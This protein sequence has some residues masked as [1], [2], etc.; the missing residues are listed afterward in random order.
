MRNLSQ[1]IL[2]LGVFS[3]ILLF[4]ARMAH[5]T[6]GVLLHGVGAVDSA[7]GG[8]S[9][10]ISQDSLGALTNNPATLSDLKATRFDFGFGLILPRVSM[11]SSVGPFSGKTNAEKDSFP[12]PAFGLAH[13]PKES[14][15]TFGFGVLGVSGF[16]LDY[17]QDSSNPLLAPSPAGLGHIFSNYQLLKIVPSVAYKPGSAVSVGFALNL[18]L[19]SMALQPT[20]FAA[21]D[22]DTATSCFYPSASNAANAYGIGFQLGIQYRLSDQLKFG[23]AYTS[24]QRFQKFEWNGVHDNPKLPNFGAGYAFSLR[25]DAPQIAGVGLGWEPQPNL[26]VAA[27]LRWINYAN[28]K[29]YNGEGFNTDGSLKGLGWDNIWVVGIGVQYCPMPNL[30]LRLGYNYSQNPI[31]SE[32][33]SV[34]VPVPVLVE[35]RLSTGVGVSLSPMVQLNL[36]Y[37][38]GFENSVDGPLQTPAGPVP[39]SKVKSTVSADSVLVQLSYRFD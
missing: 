3:L 24:P 22:C 38:H 32:Q 7:M 1:K 6:N 14:S 25:V 37:Y 18:D 19:A 29:G 34:N 35:H 8:A 15:F 28:T 5:A 17:P 26:L 2:A 30:A 4:G 36:A 9:T 21:P 27:D 10:A 20:P 16:G 12:V 31:P 11:E 23:A 13:Q 39:G 33:T